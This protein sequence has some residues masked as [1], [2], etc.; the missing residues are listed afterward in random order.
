[1]NPRK[2]YALVHAILPKVGSRVV[3]R[4]VAG[5][6]LFTT[7]KHCTI[8]GGGWFT[9]SRL[10]DKQLTTLCKFIEDNKDYLKSLLK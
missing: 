7:G 6:T 2:A 10:T 3:G 1:M 8:D 9:V 4:I 5:A